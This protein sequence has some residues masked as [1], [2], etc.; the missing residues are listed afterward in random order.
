MSTIGRRLAE[1]RERSGL[2]Q[3]AFAALCGVS[4]QSQIN[5]ESG[6]RSPDAEYLKNLSDRGYDVLYILRGEGDLAEVKTGEMRE[7]STNV[8]SPVERLLGQIAT[9]KLS[10]GDASLII[11]LAERLSASVK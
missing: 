1:I 4:R 2:S 9:L 11:A 8:Y 10:D 3:G 6:K 5:Y 7:M